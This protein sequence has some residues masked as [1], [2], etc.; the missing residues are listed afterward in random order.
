MNAD[1]FFLDLIPLWSTPLLEMGVKCEDGMLN[2]KALGCSR[3]LFEAIWINQA[4]VKQPQENKLFHRTFVL[5]LLIKSG[6]VTLHWENKLNQGR[7]IKPLF[8]TLVQVAGEV[9]ASPITNLQS[10]I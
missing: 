7:E 6:N 9:N 1:K 10:L 4:E 3:C 5:L 2:V 8:E